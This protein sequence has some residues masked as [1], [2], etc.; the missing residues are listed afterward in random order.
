MRGGTMKFNA[1]YGYGLFNARSSQ[2]KFNINA[3]G[4]M[5]VNAR[6]LKWYTK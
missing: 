1:L 3:R 5:L 2:N 6:S 4:L